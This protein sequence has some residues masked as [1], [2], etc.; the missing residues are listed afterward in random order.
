M[1]KFKYIFVLILI[2]LVT[3][4]FEEKL[5]KTEYNLEDIFENGNWIKKDNSYN[6]TLMDGAKY[7]FYFD[8]DIYENNYFAMERDEWKAKYYY[9]LDKVE[10]GTCK[11]VYGNAETIDGN[12]TSEELNNIESLIF[13][14]NGFLEGMK[15]YKEDL[16]IVESSIS[17]TIINIENR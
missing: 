5:N 6:L 16:F 15:L 12:C 13:S 1:K 17:K 4:C 7:Y 14:F 3:G 8:K 10:V 11:Y 2:L 9:S